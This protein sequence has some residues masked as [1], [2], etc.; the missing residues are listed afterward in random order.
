VC[1][2][3]GREVCGYFDEFVYAMR[4]CGLFDESVCDDESV[5]FLMIVC[6]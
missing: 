5:D 6:V 4:L 3:D 2:D 1:D